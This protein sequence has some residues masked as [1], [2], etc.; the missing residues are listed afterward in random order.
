MKPTPYV[1]VA[2]LEVEVR[3][4]VGDVVVYVFLDQRC[5]RTHFDKGY[6]HS[7]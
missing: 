3:V 5:G 4:G 1:V 2:G 6:I 7:I